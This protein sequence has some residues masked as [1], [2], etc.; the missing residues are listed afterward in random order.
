MTITGAA[1]VREFRQNW[2]VLLVAFACLLFAFSAPAFVMPFLYPEVIREFGWSREQAVILASWKYLTGSLVAIVV[3]RFIDV[4][5]VRRVLIAVSAL[6]GVAL[7]SFL[8]T[9]NLAVYYAAGIM[10]GFS[11]AGTMVSIKVLVSRTFHASQGTAMGIVM[12]STSLGQMIV[13]FAA[14]LL[15]AAWGWRVGAALLSAGI[16]IVALPL[17][18]C[19]LCDRPF[20]DDR[21]RPSGGVAAGVDWPVARALATRRE[22]WLIAFAVFAAGFVD[23]AFIQHQVLYLQEDLGLGVTVVATA[24]GA[25][26]LVS[27]AT[28]PFVGGLFDG[29]SVRGVSIAYLALAAACVTALGAF[30]PWLL[31]GFVVFRAVGHSAVLLD[32]LVLAKHTFGVGHIGLLL[33]LYTAAVNVGFAAGPPVVARLYSVTGSYVV[34]FLLCTVVALIAA[35]VLLPVRPARWVGA[36]QGQAVGPSL[37]SAPQE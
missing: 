33:G 9:P 11:G 29:L 10:L 31:A 7:L 25:I 8:W 30:N 34:P 15:M 17:M 26:G 5:G 23:Q 37:V 24:V 28:R 16:W 12:L 21:A 3:G 22:F 20:A 36:R 19:C 4:L 18:I 6:G 1:F 32:T 2:R 13:P 14:T 27:V 35:A